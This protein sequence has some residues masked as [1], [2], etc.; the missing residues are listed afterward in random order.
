MV[1]RQLKAAAV[2]EFGSQVEAARALGWTE[3]KLSRLI[4]GPD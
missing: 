3:S 4:N 2:L 1:N